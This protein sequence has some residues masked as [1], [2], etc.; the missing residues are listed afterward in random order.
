MTWYFPR[1]GDGGNGTIIV[2]YCY[3]DSSTPTASTNAFYTSDP[4]STPDSVFSRITTYSDRADITTSP[5]TRVSFTNT[6][7]NS[8]IR[9]TNS[10]SRS[11]SSSPSATISS[12]VTNSLTLTISSS[13]SSSPS[14][15][16]I[17]FAS[18]SNSETASII[19][20]NI[21]ND[22]YLLW[23]AMFMLLF[24]VIILLIIVVAV[25]LRSNVYVNQSIEMQ[26]MTN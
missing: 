12:S 15:T 26:T 17:N 6:C 2:T 9:N 1:A 7:S 16:S 24:I 14:V 19:N 22:Y 10:V 8:N 13:A 4:S 5:T 11:A 25:Y 3:Y 21:L 23:F 18:Y 20:T